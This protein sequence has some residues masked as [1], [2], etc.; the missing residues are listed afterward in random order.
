MLEGDHIGS[1]L[2]ER[3]RNLTVTRFFE[4]QQQNSSNRKDGDPHRH[5]T[6]TCR[7][8]MEKHCRT[9]YQYE[10]TCIQRTTCCFELYALGWFWLIFTL[11]AKNLDRSYSSFQTLEYA[12][13]FSCVNDGLWTEPLISHRF[14]HDSCTSQPCY[15]VCLFSTALTST[16]SRRVSHKINTTA[17]RNSTI[18]PKR[19]R[20]A[21]SLWT[22]AGGPMHYTVDQKRL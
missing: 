21:S 10:N 6:G 1:R 19:N 11:N 5:V 17:C 3:W 2:V 9:D 16:D 4:R 14:S 7:H 12:T 20:L 15:W 22:W 8:V 13:W 18:F